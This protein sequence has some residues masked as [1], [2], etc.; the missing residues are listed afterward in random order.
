VAQRRRA[1][2]GV[3]LRLTSMLLHG[4]WDSAGG[5]RND[6]IGMAVIVLSLPASFA[7]VI[8]VFNLT[9]RPEREAMRAVMVPEVEAGVITNEELDALAG[10][11]KQRRAYRKA[12][13]SRSDRRAR[14]H[15]LEAA[16]DLADQLAASAGTDSAQVR[17]ARSETARLRAG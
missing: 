16:H 2:L 4:L 11:W 15:R 10:G 14:D 12:A 6:A 5:Y 7:A 3:G 13:H 9:V 8:T 1:G 17:H